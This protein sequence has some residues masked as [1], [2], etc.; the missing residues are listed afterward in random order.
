MSRID[1]LHEI[2][3]KQTRTIVGLMSGTSLDGIDAALVDISGTGTDTQVTLRAFLTHPF[4]AGLREQIEETLNGT[5]EDVCVLNVLFG[6]ASA[7]AVKAVVDKAGIP[8]SAVD[9]VASHGQTVYHVDR[10]HGAVP[11]TLQIG[12]GAVIAERT[13]RIVV[14]DFRPRDIAAG[15]GGAPLVA[16]VDHCLFA[17]PGRTTLLQNIGG[18]A[19]VTVVSERPEDVIAF[20]TGP[21]NLLIDAVVRELLGDD[22]A[23]DRDGSYSQLGEVDEELLGSLLA[24]EYLRLPPPKTTGREL[25]GEGMSR[26]LIEGYDRERLIDLLAT[27]VRFTAVSIANAY[28]DFVVDRYEIAEVIVSGGGVHNRTLMSALERELDGLSIPLRTFA[29]TK[30]GFTA[31]AKEAVAFAMLA[32]ETVQGKPSNLPAATG[33]RGPVILG[34]IV[35]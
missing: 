10:S 9:L 30:S 34:K 4:L 15:G 25:F 8:M 14:S 26:R 17:K 33:A 7:D 3:H 13:G 1:D 23:F 6:E 35:L 20:D 28:R 5:V 11:S 22:Q 21:G 24:M 2:A 32:N 18:I 29:D 12:E 27:V 19:N 16:Y 31:D